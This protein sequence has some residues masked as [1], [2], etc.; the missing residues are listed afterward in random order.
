MHTVA[1][2]KEN[3]L[4]TCEEDSHKKH[5]DTNS[6]HKYMLHLFNKYQQQLF[7]A[8]TRFV[9]WFLLLFFLI[10]TFLKTG[11]MQNYQHGKCSVQVFKSGYF[12]SFEL[13]AWIQRKESNSLE[14]LVCPSIPP[15]Y[16]FHLHSRYKQ[17]ISVR[18]FKKGNSRAVQSVYRSISPVNM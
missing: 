11:S 15:V 6:G 8:K 12:S 5:V 10:Q 4:N 17:L 18:V 9:F 2:L 3:P 14:L 1:P 7:S 13:F 16:Q